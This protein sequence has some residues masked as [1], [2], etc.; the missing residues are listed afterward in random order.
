MQ[1]FLRQPYS[2]QGA[3]DFGQS[4]RVMVAV[5]GRQQELQCC[6]LLEV[7]GWGKYTQQNNKYT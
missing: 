2:V 4:S 6:H 1:H 5:C 3:L 7:V